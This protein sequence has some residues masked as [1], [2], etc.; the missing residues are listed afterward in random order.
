MENKNNAHPLERLVNRAGIEG[1]RRIERPFNDEYYHRAAEANEEIRQIM[2]GYARAR[3]E[4][5]HIWVR[6]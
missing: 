5:E 6:G 4:A 3:Q 2:L 1:A